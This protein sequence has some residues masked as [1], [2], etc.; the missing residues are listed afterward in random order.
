MLYITFINSQTSPTNLTK[1]RHKLKLLLIQISVIKSSSLT[2]Y[3]DRKVI[4]NDT[5]LHP[6]V[7]HVISSCNDVSTSLEKHGLE[8]VRI[9]STMS[10][11]LLPMIIYQRN[12][13]VFWLFGLISDNLSLQI[14]SYI[15]CALYKKI[16]EWTLFHLSLFFEHVFVVLLSF[17]W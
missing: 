7:N 14:I 3:R 13:Q 8:F 12:F 1:N 4:R 11:W 16:E 10:W 9:L 15:L 5:Y 6:I 2:A 17:A